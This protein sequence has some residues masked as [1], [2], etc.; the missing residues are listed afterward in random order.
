MLVELVLLQSLSTLL[1]LLVTMVL[2]LMLP[3]TEESQQ[4]AEGLCVCAGDVRRESSHQRESTAG[5]MQLE[6]HQTWFFPKV[7][8]AVVGCCSS[9][10]TGWYTKAEAVG[11]QAAHATI[12]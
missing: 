4:C 3:V 12:G 5:A 6:T 10:L 2:T 9:S 8:K 1:G 7:L 11:I